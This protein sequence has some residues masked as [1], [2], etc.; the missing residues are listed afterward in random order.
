MQSLNTHLAPI[1]TVGTVAA[2]LGRMEAWKAD[3]A[4]LKCKDR[5]YV[6]KKDILK[7][8]LA[9]QDHNSKVLTWIENDGIPDPHHKEIKQKTVIDQDAYREAGRWFIESECFKSWMT[10][11]TGHSTRKVVWLKG[12]SK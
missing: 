12:T 9:T 6:A 2:L 1:L 3:P 11:G 8:C 4:E 5:D 10:A 7:D